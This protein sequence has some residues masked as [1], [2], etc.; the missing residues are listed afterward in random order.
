MTEL[1]QAPLAAAIVCLINVMLLI[2]SLL[3][4][5][6]LYSRTTEIVRYLR[7]RQSSKNSTKSDEFKISEPSPIETRGNGTNQKAQN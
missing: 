6:D 1:F 3:M 5:S 2:F 4:L 7:A